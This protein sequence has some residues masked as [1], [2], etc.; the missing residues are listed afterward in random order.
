M[1]RV[2]LMVDAGDGR[3][4][5]SGSLH[6]YR[7]GGHTIIGPDPG[8]VYGWRQS[9]DMDEAARWWLVEAE[10]AGDAR[11]VIMHQCV[12]ANTGIKS[13]LGRILAS[14]ARDEPLDHGDKGRIGKRYL[15]GEIVVDR[16]GE[17]RAEDAEC[18]QH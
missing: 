4:K 3:V 14:G 8:Y 12:F 11:I 17:A 7:G 10:S 13:T 2:L 1:T 16:P 18:R 6:P 9:R 15:A 5:F